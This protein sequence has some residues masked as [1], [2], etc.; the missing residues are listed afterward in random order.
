MRCKTQS[1]FFLIDPRKDI[2]TAGPSLATLHHEQKNSSAL[3]V[4]VVY[5]GADLNLP[6]GWQAAVR[7]PA[8]MNPVQKK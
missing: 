1:I 7:W 8:D 6:V 3:D 5:V 4:H 2:P